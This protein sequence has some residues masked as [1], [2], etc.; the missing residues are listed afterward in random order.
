MQHI[1]GVILLTTDI[2]LDK[3]GRHLRIP[4]QFWKFGGGGDV[5]AEATSNAI[6]TGVKA[7]DEVCLG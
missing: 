3:L 7:N 1:R 6:V 2:A 5:R 4:F